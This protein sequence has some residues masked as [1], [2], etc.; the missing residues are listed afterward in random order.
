MLK[1]VKFNLKKGEKIIKLKGFVKTGEI[2]IA[3]RAT[4]DFLNILDYE[5]LLPRG[6]LTRARNKNIGYHSCL[7]MCQ[8]LAPQSKY[9]LESYSLGDNKYLIAL[10][11]K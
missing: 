4:W 9:R 2:S 3:H 7:L 11:E 10:I 1:N 8:R 6:Y 5:G